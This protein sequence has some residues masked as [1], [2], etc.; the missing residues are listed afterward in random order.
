MDEATADLRDGFDEEPGSFM[1]ALRCDLRWDKSKFARLTEAM[2]A[3]VRARDPADP[4]PRWIA[5]GYWYLDTF[6]RDWACHPNF[7]R[8]HD[9]AYYEQAF[10]RLHDLAFWLFTGSSPYQN[11]SGFEPL[12]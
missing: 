7:P 9:E 3:F 12:G 2:L 8:E 10:Q 4:I 1:L 5:E 6:V 11:G